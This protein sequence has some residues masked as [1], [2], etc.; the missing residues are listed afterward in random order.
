[1]HPSDPFVAGHAPRRTIRT[2]VLALLLA[3]S[4]ALPAAAS[5]AS[6]PYTLDLG[7]RNDFVGQTNLV[8]CVGASMQMMINMIRPKNDRT[9]KTQLKLQKLARHWSGRRPDGSTRSGASVWGWSAGLNIMDAGPYKVVG[10]DT[11]AEALRA[12][13]TAM[14]KT[15]RPVG[16]LVWRGRH[17]WVMSGFRATADPLKSTSFRVTAVFVEDPLYPNRRSTWGPTPTPG[18]ALSTTELGRQFVPRRPRSRWMSSFR[19]Q[20]VMVLPYILDTQR[21]AGLY[22]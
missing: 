20:Y 22:L 15:R 5:G 21:Y 17:A 12:A 18:E 11:L 6:K 1:M 2:L 14:R 7:R 4:L 8:Q 13:A 16:L 19:N 3:V 9:A 10:H